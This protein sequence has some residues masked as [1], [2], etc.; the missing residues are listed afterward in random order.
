LP[1]RR[2]GSPNNAVGQALQR[3]IDCVGQLDCYFDELSQAVNSLKIDV[4]DDDVGL[5][6]LIIG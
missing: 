6:F 3:V 2:P 5:F 4:S 1:L